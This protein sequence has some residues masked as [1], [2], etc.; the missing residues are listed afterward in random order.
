MATIESLP[1]EVLHLIFENLCFDT[2][3]KV[4]SSVSRIWNQTIRKSPKFSRQIKLNLTEKVPDDFFETRWPKLEQLTIP[5][6]KEIFLPSS[7]SET[8]SN[9]EPVEKVIGSDQEK[10]TM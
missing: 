9:D 8:T 5:M 6:K 7:N 10:E 2:I 4:C 1:P 3:H